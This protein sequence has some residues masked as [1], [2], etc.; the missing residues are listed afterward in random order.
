M[1]EYPV[2][3][4]E[5]GRGPRR[6]LVHCGPHYAKEVLHAV[7]FVP[8]AD[9][10]A[11]ALLNEVRAGDLFFLA[12]EAGVGAVGKALHPCRVAP[13]P[14]WRYAEC[15]PGERGYLAELRLV[16]LPEPVPV[17]PGPYLREL[18]PAAATELRAA[19]GRILPDSAA[20]R[21]G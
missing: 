8:K 7:V 13:F 4:E 5:S 3:T 19:I 18:S 17:A 6:F 21:N 16:L 1:N 15:T 20:G 11:A 9:R 12:S 14:A 10:K 2:E